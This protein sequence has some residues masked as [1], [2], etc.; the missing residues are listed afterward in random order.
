[1]IQ[2]GRWKPN[3]LLRAWIAHLGRQTED[4]HPSLLLAT[5]PNKPKDAL[6][7]PVWARLL[8][9]IAGATA[10]ARLDDLEELRRQ[11]LRRPLPFAPDPSWTLLQEQ[12]A[13]SGLEAT[14]LDLF[15]S[16]STP[17]SSP[18]ASSAP[19]ASVRQLWD[20]EAPDW[21]PLLQD[22]EAPALALRVLL[23]LGEALQEGK[24][25]LPPGIGDPWQPVEEPTP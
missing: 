17:G 4:G 24:E 2:P 3:S 5:H 7:A 1:V 11:G 19:P 9:P 8:P 14:D 25:T 20:G 21:E 12:A 10:A 6:E 18:G 13:A 16:T 15:A 23:P 22:P